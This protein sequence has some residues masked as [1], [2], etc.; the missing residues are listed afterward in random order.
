MSAPAPESTAAVVPEAPP[1]PA[2]KPQPRAS[3]EFDF[4]PSR[5]DVVGQVQVVTTGPDDTLPDLARRFNLGYEE[6]VRA[7]PGVDPWLPG[8]GREIVLPTRFVLPDAPR[9]GLVVNIAAMRLYYFP[10]HGAGQAAKVITHPIGI[11]K[12]GWS[13]PE[14][15]T[16]IQAR[17]KD[18]F[19]IPPLSV[20]KEHHA[21]GDELP[22]R[23]PPGPDNPLGAYLLRLGWPTYLIHGTNK[24][25]G[26]GMRSSHGCIR[27]YPED[28][29]EF[30]KMLPLGTSVRVVN[31]PYVLGWDHER[32][33][34]QAFGSLSDDKRDWEKG[35]R[36]LLDH[37]KNTHTPLWQKIRAHLADID[38]A[39]ADGLGKVTR[40]VPESVM[41]ATPQTQDS[42]IKSALRVQNVLP[43]GATWAGEERS[44]AASAQFQ[45]VL[46]A[47]ESAPDQPAG[48]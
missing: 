47:R 37:S 40:G 27:L 42:V 8:V 9:V 2:L 44:S 31:Q 13:T 12:V 5:D 16:Q 4:Y 18:P 35:A 3:H 48:R 30:Y 22:A 6:I 43:K 23:V 34:A 29:A 20:R 11:G 25:Y 24:P 7:N 46:G 32:L 26:V 10:P 21:D 19:W 17:V 1:S 33:L 41:K 38:W 15:V 28:I 36:Q 45:E 39:A 14:G